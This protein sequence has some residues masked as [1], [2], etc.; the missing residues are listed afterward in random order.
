MSFCTELM[1]SKGFMEIH[2][3]L[4]GSQ[5]GLL[6]HTN[7]MEATE[8]EDLVPFTGSAF[9]EL[10]YS[11]S[12]RE[13]KTSF[14]LG[15]REAKREIAIFRGLIVVLKWGNP[16]KEMEAFLLVPFKLP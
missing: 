10:P 12:L 8:M 7:S 13:C 6:P 9:W 15:V 16:P 1:A 14:G 5:N 2:S 4:G 11:V 3:Q